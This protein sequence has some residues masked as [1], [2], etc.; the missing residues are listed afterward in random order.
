VTNLMISRDLDS[1]RV[2]LDNPDTS[3]M[4]SKTQRLTALKLLEDA[5]TVQTKLSNA[6]ESGRLSSS[7]SALSLLPLP[8][9]E[10]EEIENCIAEAAYL[11]IVDDTLTQAVDTV[12]ELSSDVKSLLS[13]ILENLR[14]GTIDELNQ[15]LV[16]AHRVGWDHSFIHKISLLI[17]EERNRLIQE[18]LI[19]QKLFQMI[20]DIK[21]G[22][23]IKQI[24]IMQ[25][26][27]R[28]KSL[29]LDQNTALQPHIQLLDKQMKRAAGLAS[30]EEE[31]L[32]LIDE[33]DLVKLTD[34]LSG[35]GTGRLVMS[36]SAADVMK[37]WMDALELACQLGVDKSGLQHTVYKTG[38]LEKAARGNEGLRNWRQRFFV[39]EGLSISYFTKQGGEK[40]GCVRV[41]GGAVRILS[42]EDTG[43]R[44][45]CF[46][47][48]EGRDLS[49]ID[50]D[51]LFE[52]RK[53][54]TPLAPP[55][56][57]PLTSA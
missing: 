1:L 42:G 26:M 17:F 45:Y 55:P 25:L 33:R 32:R 56:P 35:R 28:I 46:E 11:N 37:E 14:T 7:S 44:N 31:I 20:A 47:L 10:L 29:K 15:S 30:L 34:I 48:Q 23:S 41:G 18:E 5:T 36:A 21:A 2:A 52:A 57:F 16:E 8:L 6:I 4:L 53:Q 43:G 3:T 38:I 49:N 24:E 40:K 39:L 19:K 50:P 51:L 22:Q 9:G 13:P 12:A 54:V 27:R